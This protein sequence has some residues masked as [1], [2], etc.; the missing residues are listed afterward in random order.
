MK[1][2]MN[3]LIKLIRLFIPSFH[4]KITW[5]LVIFGISLIGTPLIEIIINKIFETQFSIS[6]TS[7][8]DI[9]IGI[10][11]IVI[12]LIYN[13]L[14]NYLDKYLLHKE[15]IKKL[16][17]NSSKDKDL[18]KKLLIE[19][20]SSGSIDFLRNHDFYN[21]FR[22]NEY[23]Q[24]LNFVYEWDNAE[25]EFINKDIEKTRKRLLGEI[26]QFLDYSGTK[27]YPLKT[28]F[29]TVMTD[30]DSEIELSEETKKSISKLNEYGSSIY[31][32]HQELIR[33]GRENLYI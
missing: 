10:V 4:N 33:K 12:A 3:D 23:N 7:E 29:Q 25:H 14:T 20:P 17:N 21:P 24:L 1:F 31:N 16:E 18:Y 15:T 22:I 13:I 27:T 9:T 2:S 30:I 11:I 5:L 32:L 28:D 8:N 26:N 6:I 19:L